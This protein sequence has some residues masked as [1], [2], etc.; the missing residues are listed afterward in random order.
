MAFILGASSVIIVHL[1]YVIM[2]FTYV[3]NAVFY[4]LLILSFQVSAQ[5]G[6]E[7]IWGG[8]NSIGAEYDNSTFNGG[9][10]DWT[11]EGL[12]SANQDSAANGV[13]RWDENGEMATGAYWGAT[14]TIQSPTVANG[15]VGF[16]SDGYDNAGIKNNFGKGS[17]PAPQKSVLTSPSMDCAGEDKVSLMFY[18]SMRNLNTSTRVEV[19]NDGGNNWVSYS[20]FYNDILSSNEATGGDGWTYVDISETAAN[21]SDVRV[22]FV[23]DGQYYYWIIDD[24]SLIK[25]PQN[26]LAIVDYFYPA[27]SYSQPS[28]TDVSCD[29][30]G[31]NCVIR[32]VAGVERTDVAVW[33][34]VS[35]DDGVIY[36]DSVLIANL[37]ATADGTSP[38]DTIVFTNL[39]S[40]GNTEGD[41]TIEYS[42]TDNTQ[43]FN[44]GDNADGRGYKIS[45]TTFAKGPGVG[46]FPFPSVDITSFLA[47]GSFYHTCDFGAQ[48][49][50]YV[51]SMGFACHKSDLAQMTGATVE[52][53]IYKVD[54]LKYPN[55]PEPGMSIP[56][57]ELKGY[58]EYTYTTEGLEDSMVWVTQFT[59]LF[60]DDV[61]VILEPNEEYLALVET[62]VNKNSVGLSIGYSSNMHYSGDGGIILLDGNVYGGWSG[63][64][65]DPQIV[66]TLMFAV[67]SKLPKLPDNVITVMPNPVQDQLNLKL[68]FEN[69][70][71]ISYALGTMTGSLLQTGQWKN[72]LNE[73]KTLDVSNLPNGQYLVRIQTEEGIATKMFVVAR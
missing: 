44:P 72:A 4:F 35:D 47:V 69:A 27:G 64:T 5:V 11:T 65:A 53:W 43:D 24:V 49:E 39:W 28:M 16:D 29:S 19:S 66:L 1:K 48:L 14:G 38:E 7:Y 37:L 55:D 60:G 2:K 46:S 30:M 21:Q 31:F 10:N 36:K 70:T 54:S 34:K 67:D 23:W 63:S 58:V 62:S 56:G 20:V 57:W 61:D 3:K 9:L 51:D 73:T 50:I 42:I 45:N 41:Y 40:P 6:V 52:A 32:N 18:E 25:S 26:D 12:A 8:P 33:V 59:D 13:W 22:R 71:D 68:D 17:A 15:A